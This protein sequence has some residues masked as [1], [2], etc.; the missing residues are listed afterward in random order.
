MTHDLWATLNAKILEY[1]SDVS[2]ADM[3]NSQHDKQNGKVVFTEN[4]A[5]NSK[6]E[7]VVNG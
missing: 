6:Q 2:L 7:A 3:V 1:L 5:F 4:N